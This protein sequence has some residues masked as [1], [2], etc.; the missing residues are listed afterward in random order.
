MQR[1]TLNMQ[2]E[3]ATAGRYAQIGREL[4][5]LMHHQAAAKLFEAQQQQRED[6]V[7]AREANVQEMGE[8]LRSQEQQLAA[9]QRQLQASQAAG[10]LSPDASG[11]GGL[12]PTIQEED[13]EA[14]ARS[15]KKQRRARGSGKQNTSE[16]RCAR[17]C[18]EM[19]VQRWLPHAR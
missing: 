4:Q 8:A 5:E 2:R 19:C 9:R 17:R 12:A 11:S 16:S 6:A 3:E 18:G 7:A 1:E 10:G 15:G 14:P 13:I